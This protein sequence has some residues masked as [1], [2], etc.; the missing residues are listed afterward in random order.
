MELLCALLKEK[1]VNNLDEQE[2]KLLEA[3]LY[4]TRMKYVEK[5]GG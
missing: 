4:E 1:T 3:L 2:G 5:S